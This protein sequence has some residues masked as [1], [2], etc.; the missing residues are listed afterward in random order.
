MKP[1]NLVA[2]AEAIRV[3]KIQ[4]SRSFFGQGLWHGDLLQMRE[5]RPGSRRHKTTSRKNLKP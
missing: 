2:P 5:D 1:T 4:K 3:R